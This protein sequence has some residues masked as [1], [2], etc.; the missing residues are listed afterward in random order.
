MLEASTT[1]SPRDKVRVVRRAKER[2][3]Q[4]PPPEGHN[5]KNAISDSVDWIADFCFKYAEAYPNPGPSAGQL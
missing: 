1:T 2:G 3:M 5:S 4:I